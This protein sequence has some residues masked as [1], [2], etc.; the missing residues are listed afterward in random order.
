MDQGHER[1]LLLGPHSPETTE[2]TRKCTQ[3]LWFAPVSFQI[4]GS[5]Y[6]VPPL[7]VLSQLIA[8]EFR[9]ATASGGTE[10]H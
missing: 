8:I 7:S 5:S 1:C 10:Y 4:P 2:K 3:F 6:R 9:I